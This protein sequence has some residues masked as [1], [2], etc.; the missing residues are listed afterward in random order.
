MLKRWQAFIR[1]L[2]GGRICFSN[3]AGERALRGNVLGRKARLFAGSD[4]ADT[5]PQPCTTAKMNEV[6]PEAWL[7][8][9]SA[10][11]ADHPVQKA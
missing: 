4:R 10:R 3:N 6:D 2:H 7:A 1:F 11:I 5:A 8:D 9:V